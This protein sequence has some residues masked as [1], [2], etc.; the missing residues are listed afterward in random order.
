[1]LYSSCFSAVLATVGGPWAW[2]PGSFLLEVAQTSLRLCGGSLDA[3]ARRHPHFA[4]TTASVS[5]F[6]HGLCFL[7]HG[8]PKM[9]W[10]CPILVTSNVICSQCWSIPISNVTSTSTLPSRCWET[11]PSATTSP[12]GSSITVVGNSHARTTSSDMKLPCA[13]E[14]I[15]ASSLRPWIVT[16]MVTCPVLPVFAHSLRS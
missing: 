11:V 16:A 4:S 13:P 5:Q 7:I 3:F 9:I 12:Y 1:M 10:C 6:I 8:N 14:S 2:C 15:I